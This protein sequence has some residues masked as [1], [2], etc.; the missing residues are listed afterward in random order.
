MLLSFHFAYS[1]VVKI[2]LNKK[3]DYVLLHPNQFQSMVLFLFFL[4]NI[5]NL[6]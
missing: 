1:I 4:Y 3:Y 6:Y 5:I 2:L